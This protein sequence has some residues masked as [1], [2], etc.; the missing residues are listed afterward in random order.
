MFKSIIRLINSTK[1]NNKE[2]KISENTKNNSANKGTEKL[3]AI[4]HIFIQGHWF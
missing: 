1:K 2:K 3:H 4:T